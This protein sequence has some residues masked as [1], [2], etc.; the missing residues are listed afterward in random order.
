MR[1]PRSEL[2]EWHPGGGRTTGWLGVAGVTSPAVLWPA[3]ISE[4]DGMPWERLCPYLN[5]YIKNMFSKRITTKLL[6]FAD[7]F[8]KL[9]TNQ[10]N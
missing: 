10:K 8:T 9:K 3:D 6:A 2:T 7:K 1:P 5:Y 4:A